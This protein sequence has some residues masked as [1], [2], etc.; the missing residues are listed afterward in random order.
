MGR[1]FLVQGLGYGDEGKGS[2]VDYLVR[3]EQAPLVVRFN[4]GAQAAH[5]VVTDD[6]RHHTFSQF[7]SGTLAG[8]RTFLSRHMLVN[9]MTLL[10]EAKGLEGIGV[11]DPLSR[12]VVE[13]GAKLTSPFHM[14]ANR[15]R[16]IL[17]SEG[18]HGSC[19]MG[20]G[21]T[22][23][24]DIEHP[25]ET[26][27]AFLL[28]SPDHCRW[29]L[30]QLR[31][32][33]IEE[34]S[35]PIF[36][37]EKQHGYHKQLSTEFEMLNDVEFMDEVVE[38][39][40]EVHKSIEIVGVTWL[41]DRMKEDA[42][43][44]FEGAQG[45]LLDQ[46]Y[47]WAPYNTWSDCTFGN[48]MKLIRPDA[49]VQKIGVL[50]G[51]MTRHGAGPFTTEDASMTAPGDHNG[52]GPWQKNFRVGPFDAIAS[53][54]A[55]EVIGGVHQLALTCLDHL[56]TGIRSCS[57]YAMRS[58]AFDRIDVRRPGEEEAKDPYHR[59]QQHRQEEM[60]KI[61]SFLKPVYQQIPDVESFISHVEQEMKT[62]VKLC[63]F[64]PKASDKR[65]R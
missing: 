10:S 65:P 33:L 48:V 5:N 6:G 27:S 47:G 39:Y 54:Y 17:R 38:R 23:V 37:F 21:E 62:P 49:E 24:Q 29:A 9:P 3:R 34:L 15:I 58:K 45:V 43:V 31:K 53:R 8:A 41:H 22:V 14:A 52:D 12:V 19:G 7:G 57:S 32:R 61:L 60:G 25:E 36:D 16:E 55:L 18:R 59:R 63:S 44:V 13:M 46:D 50:R 11:Q 20:I 51:Y 40:G 56:N 28:G 26:L 2:V 35:R 30:R 4:G 64:G 42:T 1:A